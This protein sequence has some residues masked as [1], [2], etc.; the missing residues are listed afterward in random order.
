MNGKNDEW[1]VK[2]MEGGDRTL[3]EMSRNL[4]NGQRRNMKTCHNSRCTC[5]NSNPAPL[6]YKP[7]GFLLDQSA[8]TSEQVHR[9]RRPIQD[10]SYSRSVGNTLEEIGDV[11]CKLSHEL[12]VVDR[13]K[14]AKIAH[15]SAQRTRAISSGAISWRD[16][17]L[18][19]WK[20][21]L[22]RWNR[23]KKRSILN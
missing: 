14:H 22:A 20:A 19:G 12:E 13:K 10:P 2:D 15:R 3:I 6:K 5:R 7:S 18:D 21:F 9:V 8:W 11:E 17:I 16:Q 4:P 1:T 23:A